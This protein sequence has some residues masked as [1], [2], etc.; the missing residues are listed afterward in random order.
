[1]NN[2][3][4]DKQVEIFK[5]LGSPI[6]L[7][8][9]TGLKSNGCN[10]KTMQANLGISQSTISQ[11]LKVLKMSGIVKSGRKGNTICY[12]II[13]PLAAKIINMIKTEVL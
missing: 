1:M 4:F 11:H 6:R 7:K 9:L 12:Q 3:R 10:V 5:L 2:A 8:I 13:D